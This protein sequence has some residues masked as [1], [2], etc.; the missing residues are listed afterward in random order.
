MKESLR[1]VYK[2]EYC[3]KNMLIMGA[4]E[5]HEDFCRKNPENQHACFKMCKHLVKGVEYK[6][7]GDEWGRTPKCTTFTCS[8]TNQKM[9]S[10]IAERRDLDIAMDDAERMPLACDKYAPIEDAI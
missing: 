6:D 4:M 9:Y 8:V 5:K 1:K 10:Y 3:G 7:I 2:C